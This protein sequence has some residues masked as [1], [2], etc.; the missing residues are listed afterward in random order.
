[1]SMDRSLSAY[2]VPKQRSER[3]NRS[4]RPSRPDVPTQHVVR[5]SMRCMSGYDVAS[6]QGY[7]ARAKNKLSLEDKTVEYGC[8]MGELQKWLLFLFENRTRSRGEFANKLKTHR[9][10]LYIGKSLNTSVKTEKLSCWSLSL[11]SP[12]CVKITHISCLH[13]APCHEMTTI[14]EKNFGNG[15]WLP[16]MRQNDFCAARCSKK[17]DCGR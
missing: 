17:S 9:K 7:I 10:L 12:R 15:L 5:I 3:T 11:L 6:P 2:I 13:S 16:E 1:M 4:P 8:H 14:A